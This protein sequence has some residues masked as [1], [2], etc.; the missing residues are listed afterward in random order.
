MT[1]ATVKDLNPGLGSSFP[2]ELVALGGQVL[3]RALDPSLAFELFITDGTAAGTHLLKDIYPGIN[4]SEPELTNSVELAGELYFPASEPNSGTELWKTDGTA[5]GT[6]LVADVYPGT[7]SSDLSDLVAMNGEVYFAAAGFPASGRELWAAGSTP[8]SLRLVKDISVGPSS[9]LTGL[10]VSG[11]RVFFQARD[12]FVNAEP[13][14]SDGTTAGTLRLADLVAGSGSSTPTGFA[15]LPSGG[16]FFAAESAVGVELMVSDGTPAGTL[17]LKD[18]EPG[19]GTESSSPSSL[20]AISGQELFFSAYT[21]DVGNEP[22]RWTA[23]GGVQQLGEITPGAGSFDPASA[24]F[25]EVWLGDHHRTFFAAFLSSTGT[26]LWVTDG[27]AS[28]MQLVT[29]INPGPASDT[30]GNFLPALDRLFFTADSV[31]GRGLWISDGTAAGTVQL[32]SDHF[33]PLTTDLVELGDQVL[34]PFSDSSN[35]NELWTTDGTAAGTHLLIDLYGPG[36][37]SPRLLTRV[38]DKVVFTAQTGASPSLRDVFITDGTAAGTKLLSPLG[39]GPRVLESGG[40]AVMGG[41]AYFLANVQNTELWKVDP[42]T[43]TLIFVAVAGQPVLGFTDPDLTATNDKL[44]FH[45]P[46]TDALGNDLG[47]ELIVSD[48]TAAGTHLVKDLAP[49]AES[50]YP[51]ELVPANG[52]VYFTLNQAKLGTQTDP[53]IEIYYSDGTAAGTYQVCARPPGVIPEEPNTPLSSAPT[54]L[55][56]AAG[57]LFWIADDPNGVGSELFRI[58]QPGAH[59]MTLEPSGSKQRISSNDPILGTTLTV[60]GTLASPTDLSVLVMSAPV[61]VPHTTLVA[62]GSA[63]WVDPA[64]LSV[65]AVTTSASWTFT[66]PLPAI[67]ALAGAQFTLQSWTLEGPT[68]FPAETSN[69]LTI[70]LGN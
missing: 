54:D 6:V 35:D 67:P 38:G 41:E 17:L 63:A 60:T 70:V 7:P 58:P 16:A 9:D 61:A 15:A 22:R 43:E 56:L 32:V 21:S 1:A 2:T 4:S 28:G 59:T 30:L 12:G 33:H 44:F 31:L 19:T 27:T 47:R 29:E 52:G 26:A 42:V 11:N 68:L 64:S 13:W 20:A 40:F 45:L 53:A 25:T 37:S 18:L 34:F 8:G 65:L 5:A 49:G 57:N 62:Y 39:I 36:W 23:A 66:S 51:T 24:R 14:V 69:G 10:T 46:I 50:S 3:F 48:G 55:T